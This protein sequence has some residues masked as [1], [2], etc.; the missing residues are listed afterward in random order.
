MADDVEE[1]RQGLIAN[2]G[3]GE[4][5]ADLR[6]KYGPGSLGC[7]EALHTARLL[8]TMVERELLEHAAVLARPEWFALAQRAVEALA[9][10]YQDIGAAHIYPDGGS[11]GG[12][13][14]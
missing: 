12:Q 10:L 4:S 3:H 5:A 11:A 9:E 8:E 6:A 14:K 1:L 7:H 13:T 2:R